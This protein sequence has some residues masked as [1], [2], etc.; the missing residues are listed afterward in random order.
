M[1]T[2][3]RETWPATRSQQHRE[4][5]SVGR[6][7]REVIAKA[8]LETSCCKKHAEKERGGSRQLCWK[9][10]RGVLCKNPAS[11]ARRGRP[12]E[13]ARLPATRRPNQSRSGQGTNKGVK[14]TWLSY[15]DLIGRQGKTRQ[16]GKRGKETKAR[17]GDSLSSQAYP[18]HM[19]R[20]QKGCDRGVLNHGKGMVQCPLP[21]WSPGKDKLTGGGPKKRV[22]PNNIKTK[23]RTLGLLPPP[24]ET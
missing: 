2:A 13:K 9:E 10:K 1:E 8:T 18:D 24:S 16:C 3:I 23:G 6:G 5:G 4:G 7:G 19:R 14:K 22:I 12:N 20:G 17:K 21:R 11:E 15:L